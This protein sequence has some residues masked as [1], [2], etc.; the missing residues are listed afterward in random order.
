MAPEYFKYSMVITALNWAGGL[1]CAY[2]TYKEMCY[3][4]QKWNQKSSEAEQLEKV[5]LEL[6]TA[7]QKKILSRLSVVPKDRQTPIQVRAEN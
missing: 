5:V 7:M 6:R 4:G 2:G 1:L 3:I